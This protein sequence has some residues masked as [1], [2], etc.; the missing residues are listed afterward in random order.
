L[1]AFDAKR[2]FSRIFDELLEEYRMFERWGL[3]FLTSAGIGLAT[4]FAAQAQAPAPTAPFSLPLDCVVGESCFLQNLIDLDQSAGSIIDSL[5]GQDTYDNHKGI[6]IR[7]LTLKDMRRGV[8]VLAAADGEVLGLR[9][10]MA[11]VLVEG[12]VPPTIKGRECGNGVGIRHANGLTTQYCHMQRGSIAVR[13]GQKV[14]RGDV[15]GKIGVSGLSAFPH[16]HLSV[17]AGEKL[18][19]VLGDPAGGASCD[20]GQ[21]KL[22]LF[23]KELREALLASRNDILQI[24]LADRPFKLDALVQGATPD[25]PTTQSQAMVA[26]GWAMNALKGDQMRIVIESDAGVFIDQTTKPRERRSAAF[27]NFAGRSRSP[28]AGVYKVTVSLIRNGQ[29]FERKTDTFNVK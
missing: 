8:N 25:V 7:V 27:V 1:R 12:A 10:E 18:V 3:R 4:A 28:E 19:D 11:D 22:D 24:G 13:K 2:L 16:L 5:C 9:D 29:A 15:L 20:I 6:D 17:R 14:K 26:W 23:G 21:T